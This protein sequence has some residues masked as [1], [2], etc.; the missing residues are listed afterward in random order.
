M[1]L[2]AQFTPGSSSPA[3]PSVSRMPD[4]SG[5]SPAHRHT[6]HSALASLA[7]LAVASERISIRCSGREA[8]PSGTVV[9]QQPAAG[10]PLHP[11]TQIHLHVAGLGFSHALPTGMWDS[12]GESAGGTREIFEAFD[13]PL[14]KLR[15]WFHEGAPLFRI[16]PEDSAACARWLA[17]FGVDAEE[18]PRPLWYRLA[19]LIASIPT[20]ACSHAGCAFALDVL[21]G[22][23]VAA[24]SWHRTMTVLPSSSLSGLGR[25]SS[26]LGVD[27][28]LGDAVEDLAL[29]E[30]E[31]GPVRLATYSY[32]VEEREGATL[33]DR[34]LHMLIPVCTSFALR[35][36]VLDKTKTPQLGMP[37]ENARLG[38]NTHMG[39]ALG[40]RAWSEK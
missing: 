34:V 13:D 28:L 4:L 31:L 7:A 36:M 33:L 14:Q 25:Q 40:E 18:W 1:E 5:G 8:L 10:Q 27:L 29:L 17:L 3:A 35:W 26:R 21:F 32:F 19:S 22:L 16:A 20:L 39:S 38:I 11:D 23:S 30:I 24:F 2:T 37:E 12:G 9:A 15:H 6:I